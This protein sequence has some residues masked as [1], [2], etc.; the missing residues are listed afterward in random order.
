MMKKVLSTLSN[1]ISNLSSIAAD[2]EYDPHEPASSRLQRELGFDYISDE[3]VEVFDRFCSEMEKEHLEEDLSDEEIKAYYKKWKKLNGISSTSPKKR[4][5]K[6]KVKIPKI[7]TTIEEAEYMWI[8]SDYAYGTLTKWLVHNKH[9]LSPEMLTIANKE[10]IILLFYESIQEADA[11]WKKIIRTEGAFGEAGQKL[12][13]LLKNLDQRMNELDGYVSIGGTDMT[14]NHKSVKSRIEKLHRRQQ[15]ELK[16]PVE[17]SKTRA[18]VDHSFLDIAQGFPASPEFAQRVI[19]T[20]Y[21]DYPEYPFISQDREKNIPNW[22]TDAA[23]FPQM[24]VPKENMKRLRNGLLPG[25]IYQLYWLVKINRKRIPGYFEY[26]Y[27]ICFEDGI[28]L[29][30]DKGFL[31]QDGSISAKGTKAM[32][33]YRYIIEEH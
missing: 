21:S 10:E 31:K 27:G 26:R 6:S 33:T 25:H 7:I 20:Y 3:E 22:I 9:L 12:E 28:R 29:L 30:K 15:N 17:K 14:N 24:V 13:V 8:K 11:L 18:Q 2:T 23:M 32:Q 16:Q 4:K 19:E 1:V 5:R